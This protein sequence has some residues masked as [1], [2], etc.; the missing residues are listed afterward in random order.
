MTGGE[1]GDVAVSPVEVPARRR[2]VARYLLHP[3]QLKDSMTLA[4]Q[5]SI[6]NA[7]LA[8]LQAAAVVAIALPLVHLSPWPHLIGFA[9][10]GALVALFGRF[11]PSGRRGRILLQCGLLQVLAVLLISAAAWLGASIGV[12]LFLLALSC[13]VFLFISVAGKFGPPGPLIFVFAA[14]ASIAPEL[15]LGQV[16]ERIVATAVVAALA[17]VVCTA[18]E[19]T[20]QA[21]T[22]ERPF[23][24]EPLRPLNHRLVAAVRSAAAAG[25]A[26]MVSLAFEGRHP[27]WA[28]MGALAVLQGPHLHVVMN[29]A[30]QR[31]A[32]TVVGALLAWLLLLQDPSIWVVI[33]ALA[34]LQLL[35]EAVIG[36]NYAFGQMLVTP[37]ALLMTSLGA[38]QTLG[39]E[40]APERVLETFVG[41]AVGVVLSVILS[42]L[43]DRRHL[44]ARHPGLIPGGVLVMRPPSGQERRR[45]RP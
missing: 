11:A 29:R 37:M 36:V 19:V 42:T 10:L 13:G 7:T 4:R 39:A 25:A 6:W 20:R 27:A 40:M 31:M 2:D 32:G 24:N 30:L 43:D 33:A 38:A 15:S 16:I 14:G 28:A 34:A 21:P 41:V 12:Q 45:L 1:P 22:A 9:S 26:I 35:T 18:T 23:P 5:A 3:A 44:A 17:W 8:G